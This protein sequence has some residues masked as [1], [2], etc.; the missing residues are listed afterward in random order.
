LQ[1]AGPFCQGQ[2][3]PCLYH[4]INV[5]K[6]KGRSSPALT[7][8]FAVLFKDNVKVPD[9]HYGKNSPVMFWPGLTGQYFTQKGHSVGTGLDLSHDEQKMQFRSSND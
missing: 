4:F 7:I 1:F 3:K 8:R 6:K 5:F 9:F 2:V